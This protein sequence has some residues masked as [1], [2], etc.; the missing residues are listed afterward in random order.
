MR[1]SEVVN[2]QHV[3]ELPAVE[4]HVAPDDVTEV[5]QVMFRNLRAVSKGGVKPHPLWPEDGEEEELEHPHEPGEDP[6]LP[7]SQ[8]LVD[9]VKLVWDHGPVEQ[10][11]MGL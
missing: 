4:H 10:L 2:Q 1:D 9:P 8:S 11:H 6:V 5:L 3:P 7:V